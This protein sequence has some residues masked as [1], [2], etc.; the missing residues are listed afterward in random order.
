MRLTEPA[1]L[2]RFFSLQNPDPSGAQRI[3]IRG[4]QSQA[5]KG[6]KMCNLTGRF[7]VNNIKILQ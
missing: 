5:D 3:E 6:Q 7:L 1:R 4:S 2:C